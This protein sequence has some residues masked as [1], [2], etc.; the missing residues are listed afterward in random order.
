MSRHCTICEHDKRGEIEDALAR[1]IPYRILAERY[2]VSPAA[3]SRHLNTHVRDEVLALLRERIRGSEK[4]FIFEEL[5]DTF[6]DDLGAFDELG[7]LGEE[8]NPHGSE[9]RSKNDRY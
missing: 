2:R 7:S 6:G 3:L 4:I 9:R 1:R 5:S 8:R